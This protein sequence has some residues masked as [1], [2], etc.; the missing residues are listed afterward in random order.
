MKE[1]IECKICKKE[2][3]EWREGKCVTCYR[4]E[5][6][7]EKGKAREM[8]KDLEVS[9]KCPFRHREMIKRIISGE[10][11][12]G[13]YAEELGVTRQRISYI[14]KRYTVRVNK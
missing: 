9:I 6:R 2:R 8:F 12:Q 4:E 13:E 14:F 11:T 10:K 1:K 5:H 3:K 7:K